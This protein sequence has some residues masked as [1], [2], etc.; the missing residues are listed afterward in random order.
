MIVLTQTVKAAAVAA[1]A[2]ALFGGVKVQA[3]TITGAGSTFAAPLYQKWAQEFKPSSGIQ[4]NYQPI[5]SSGGIKNITAH[6]VDFGAT[7]GP[8]S[9]D[10]LRAAPGILHIPTVAGAVVVAYN[11]PG[12]GAGLRMTPDVIADIFLG[13]ITNWNDPRISRLNPG[14]KFPNLAIAPF[15]RSDGSGTTGIFTNYLS[16]VSP[17]WKSSVGQGNAVRWPVGLGGNRN[18]GVT[19]LIQQYPGGI[20]YIELAY[21]VQHVVA[22]AL[23]QNAKGKFIYPSVEST[24]LAA[25]GASLPPDFRKII[26]NTAAPG[27]YPITGFTWILVFTNARPEVKKF[28]EWSLTSGQTTCKD[29]L[30]A[31]LPASIQ[32]RA[33]A[34]VATI[35]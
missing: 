33:L 19:A 28:L 5:G 1:V 12:I 35:K 10:Q 26:T 17:E 7:D 34:A 27:G 25:D 9:A 11:V 31:P 2:F 32:K 20:G 6:S 13:K 16:Q 15:H 29:L 22:Y 3:Q 23:V 30:Y 24:T 14:I 8:M 4:V 18:A 21:A